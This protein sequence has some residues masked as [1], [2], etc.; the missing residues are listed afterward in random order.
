MNKPNPYSK[1]KLFKTKHQLKNQR[2]QGKKHEIFSENKKTHTFF[3]TIEVEMMNSNGGLC[4]K[5]GGYK[6]GRQMN[7]HKSLREN[8][9]V[10]KTVLKA[11]NKRFSR[12]KQ[13]TNK[14]SG[15]VTK[16][17]RDNF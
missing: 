5:H 3:L 1:L 6:R 9:K 4:E 15:Q 10:L 2:N 16:H 11:Q 12:L 13:V 7:S 17:L 8:L 14:A